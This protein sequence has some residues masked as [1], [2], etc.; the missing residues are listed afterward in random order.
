MGLSILAV[1]CKDEAKEKKVAHDMTLDFHPGECR[2]K[3][4]EGKLA[5]LEGEQKRLEKAIRTSAAEGQRL[6]HQDANRLE[7]R[8]YYQL[9]AAQKEELMIVRRHMDLLRSELK[10]SCAGAASSKK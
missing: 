5:F 10:I 9:E 7:S 1:G 3:N 4:I 8:Q 6:Q 2:E